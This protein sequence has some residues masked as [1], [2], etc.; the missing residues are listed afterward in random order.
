MEQRLLIVSRHPAAIEFIRRTAPRF[1]EAPVLLTASV[2]DVRGA[3]VAGNVP[4]HLAA[5]A[6][7]V[8]AVEFTGP[9]PRGQE[10]SLADMEAAGAR[11][12]RY[13]VEALAEVAP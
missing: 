2:E 1:A 12:R 7:E 13:R 8:V 6:A 9:A 3:V 5:A 11:L 10:Y 4:L